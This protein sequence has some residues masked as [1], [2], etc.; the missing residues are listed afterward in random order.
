MSGGFQFGGCCGCFSQS[1]MPGYRDTK[2][3]EGFGWVMW[4][5]RRVSV[6]RRGC[7]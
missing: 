7:E 4:R 5:G 2:V 6:G 3:T 1:R